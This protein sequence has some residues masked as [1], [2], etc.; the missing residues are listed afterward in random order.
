LTAWLGVAGPIFSIDYAAL[1]SSAGIAAWVQAFVSAAAI[2][3]VYV[4]A[5][6]PVRAERVRRESELRL[7]SQGL[8]L[9]LIPELVALKGELETALQ[10]G[11]IYKAPIELPTSLNDKA[12]ELY[13]LEEVG[14]RL[15]QTIGLVRGLAIQTRRFQAVGMLQGVPV[16]SKNYCW[17]NDLEQPCRDLP[18][19]S[20]KR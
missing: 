10:N 16:Q 7:R 8:A 2:V 12:D 11:P 1:N 6:I 14:G 18:P 5:T 9:L 15:L 17:R 19:R 4:A 13:I 20:Q 3:A